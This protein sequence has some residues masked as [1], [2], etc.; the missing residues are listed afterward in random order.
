MSL[1]KVNDRFRI[2]PLSMTAVYGGGG[3]SS[4]QEC[5]LRN[6]RLFRFKLILSVL[7]LFCCLSVRK[8][9]GSILPDESSSRNFGFKI[10]LRQR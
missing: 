1:Q 4:L 9:C 6:K 7:V 2:Y 5:K 3:K 8:H 10:L